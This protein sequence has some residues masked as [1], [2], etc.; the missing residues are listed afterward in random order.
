M[1]ALTT[2]QLVLSSE[3][4]ALKRAVLFVNGLALTSES[5]EGSALSFQCIDDV[6]CG[7]GLSLSMLRVGDGVTYNV[8]QEHFQNT[9]C[10]LIDQSRDSLYTT[11]SSKTADGWLRDTLDVVTQNLAMTLCASLAQTLSSF[12]SARH[13]LIIFTQIELRSMNEDCC[14]C[15]PLNIKVGALLSN[16]QCKL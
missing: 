6:H 4:V 15:A 13:C 14:Q 5:V 16:T 10:F 8:L 9:T 2:L 7:D 11:S 1:V 3:F 12:A